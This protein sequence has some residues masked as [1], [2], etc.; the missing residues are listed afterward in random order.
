MNPCGGACTV[1]HAVIIGISTS[2]VSEHVQSKVMD[3]KKK[4]KPLPTSGVEIFGGAK[5]VLYM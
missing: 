1:G 5:Y 2:T 4:N 3:R